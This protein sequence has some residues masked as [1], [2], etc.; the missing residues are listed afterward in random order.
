MAKSFIATSD[1][2]KLVLDTPHNE[3]RFRD[4][5]TKRK[6]KKYRIEEI[7]SKRSDAQNRSLHLWF[8]MVAEELNNAG[9]SVQEVLKQKIA[10]DWNTELVKD[11]L[12]KTAQERILHKKSTTELKKQEDIDKVFDHLVRHLGEKFFIEVPPFPHYDDKDQAI[13]L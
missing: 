11:I 7:D 3:A 13:M 2:E 6:G 1:G 4:S 5:L 12:W 8:T 10:I 9:Y